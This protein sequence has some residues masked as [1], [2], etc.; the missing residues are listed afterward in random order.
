MITLSFA[1][2]FKFEYFNI[3]TPR[4]LQN[5]FPQSHE[6]AMQTLVKVYLFKLHIRLAPRIAKSP[7]RSNVLLCFIEPVVG[8]R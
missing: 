7:P 6:N 2:S 5:L 8:N 3:R 1:D 4:I